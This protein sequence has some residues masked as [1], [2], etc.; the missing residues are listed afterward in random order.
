MS[1]Q[2]GMVAQKRACDYLMAQGLQLLMAN[3][4]C[5]MGEIDLIMQ[6]DAYIVFVEV[7]ARS[8][9]SFGGA[10]ASV[11]Y[12]KQQKLIKTASLYLLINKHYDNC[13]IRFDVLSID[14]TPP[15]I[16]WIKDAFG[17]NY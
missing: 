16:S 9:A 1:K 13:P 14:G 15:C 5:R 6:D 3:Y 8:C 12:S 17:A 4:L 7:R 11:S 2:M 10:L